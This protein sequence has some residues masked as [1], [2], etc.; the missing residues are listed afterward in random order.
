MGRIR[1]YT[2]IMEDGELHALPEQT[3]EENLISMLCDY[4]W[5]V[6]YPD[7]QG[8]TFAERVMAFIKE[9]LKRYDE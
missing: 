7:Q 5:R 1:G 3:P 4:Y 9:E 2:A 8:K 6:R